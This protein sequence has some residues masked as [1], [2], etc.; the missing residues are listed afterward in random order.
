MPV[1]VRRSIIGRISSKRDRGKMFS[2]AGFNAEEVSLVEVSLVNIALW[3][4]F[5]FQLGSECHFL[6]LRNQVS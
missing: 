2:T 1:E 5:G 4:E 3:G 6:P